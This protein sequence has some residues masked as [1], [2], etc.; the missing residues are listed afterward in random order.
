MDR[1]NKEC[2]ERVRKLKKNIRLTRYDKK[3]NNF[4]KN[5]YRFDMKCLFKRLDELIYCKLQWKKGG[6][7]ETEK[8]EPKN[9]YKN[10]KINMKAGESKREQL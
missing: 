1:K 3:Y 7:R 6:E 4:L 2:I 8:N 5:S 9:K 10:K